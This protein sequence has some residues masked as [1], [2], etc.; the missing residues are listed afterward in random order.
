MK[1]RPYQ[2]EIIELI[3]KSNEKRQLIS[4]PTGTGKTIIF[5]SL[6][7][8]L[9]VPCLILAHRDELIRQAADKLL[10]VWPDADIGIVKAAENETD[11]MVTIGSVQTLARKKRREQLRP[12]IELILSDEAHHSAAASYKKIYDQFNVLDKNEQNILHC[13]FTATPM[14]NDKKG[15][16]S[17]FDTITYEGQFINFVKGGYLCDLQ[18]EGVECTLDLDG[19]K[20]TQL[21]GYGRDFQIGQLSEKVN[22]EEIR[23]N[24][25]SA[26]QKYAADR[27]HTLGFAVDRDHAWS[28]H[29]SFTAEGIKSGYIDGETP[30]DE[31]KRI[32]ND[33]RDGTIRVLWN[34]LVLTE[35][36]DCPQVDCILLARP[37]KSP[38]LL[39]Q[40][41]GRG[42][43]PAPDK[44]NCM[45]LDIA[46]A[47]RAKTD[48][49]G[50]VIGHA[51]SLL[52]LAS[53]FYPPI[54]KLS[55]DKQTK[56]KGNAPS[57]EGNGRGYTRP[58]EHWLGKSSSQKSI[59]EYL[60][61]NYEPSRSWHYEQATPRQME[62]V[63]KMLPK[64]DK[65]LSRGEAS[66]LLDKVFKKPGK[67]L[68]DENTCPKCGKW[69]R[70]K[71]ENCYTCA[72]TG[73]QQKATQPIPF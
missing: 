13:G 22:T 44:N 56:K 58:S 52:E 37:S 70:P 15:L 69:K 47:H 26:Y 9:N 29:E 57:I 18:F 17:I 14:R 10:S 20:T 7:K 24:I 34:I 67:K 64:I 2:E 27:K 72:K 66:A 73:W 16:A 23:H 30:T 40:I 61:K 11:H 60:R 8:R 53:L 55:G 71:Y 41:I 46:H 39:T 4:L 21:S 42:T 45:I 50:N 31:R 51:G 36:F 63:R 32:L 35:G 65:N 48:I 59:L 62:M 49:Y 6:A 33:F 43:R 25:I 3:L 68:P 28:L 38:T 19:V 54:K 1:L 5:S 12:D